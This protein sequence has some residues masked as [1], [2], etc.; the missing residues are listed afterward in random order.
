VASL[1]LEDGG[2]EDQAIAALLHDAAEDQGGRPRLEDIRV[3]FGETVREI[4]D[5][6]TDTF[7]DPK[8]PWRP[9]KEAYIARLRDEPEHVLRVSLADKLHNA[10]AILRDYDTL[11]ERLWARFNAAPHDILWYYRALVD[12]FQDTDSPLARELARVVSE[13]QSRIRSSTT[14]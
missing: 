3:R 13:L 10:R 1:V 5:G 6:C 14:S 7:D 12:A 4:V 8:P 9:R 2:T 11:G